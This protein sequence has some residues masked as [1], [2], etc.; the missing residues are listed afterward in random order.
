MIK[1]ALVDDNNGLR[2]LISGRL[3]ELGFD[4]VFTATSGN[5]YLRKMADIAEDR[6]PKVVLMDIEMADLN[7]I[8][9]TRKSRELFPDTKIV[10]LTVF[11]D[12]E[13]IFE[14]VKAGAHGYLLK[15]ESD[16]MLKSAVVIVSEGGAQMSAIIALKT[17][18]LLKSPPTAKTKALPESITAREKE[19]LELITQGLENKEI[20]EKLFVSYDTVKKHVA[21]IFEKLHVRNKAEAT[22]MALGNRWFNL[23]SIFV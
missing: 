21:H 12:D 22:S 19:I 11:D 8:E 5:D 7:G 2:N 6:R 18:Q 1:I 17:L 10:I 3:I 20:A 9:A 16:E 4:L 14:A 15:D 13:N 23:S